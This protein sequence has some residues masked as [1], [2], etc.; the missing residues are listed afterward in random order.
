M[1]TQEEVE[2]FF[3]IFAREMRE[4]GLFIMDNFIEIWPDL[5]TK[6]EVR[7]AEFESDDDDEL[8]EYDYL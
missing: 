7:Q 3:L 2:D 5:P 1:P 8:N 6:D 4:Q